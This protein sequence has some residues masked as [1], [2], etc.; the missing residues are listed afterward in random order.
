MTTKEDK[1]KQLEEKI[2]KY[3]TRLREKSLGYGEVVRTGYGDSYED[4]LRD[5]TNTYRSIIQSIKE[6][7]KLLK[8]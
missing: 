5:D 1:I 8:K 6:E 7:I 2:K 3:E 4:Q